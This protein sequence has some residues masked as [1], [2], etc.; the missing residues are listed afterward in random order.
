MFL[1]KI[2]IACSLTGCLWQSFFYA[3]VGY[4]AD[5]DAIIQLRTHLHP[6][7]QLLIG[8]E[9]T[10]TGVQVVRCVLTQMGRNY[11]IILSPP[12]RNR[13]LMATGKVDGLFL[14]TPNVELNKMGIATEPLALERWKFF[15][16]LAPLDTSIDPVPNLSDRIG[17]VL[18]SNEGSWLSQHRFEKTAFS[19]DM[20]SL[21]KVLL[22]KRVDYVLADEAAFYQAAKENDLSVENVGSSFVRYVPLVAHFSYDFLALNPTFLDEFNGRIDLCPAD[23][24][25]PT[26]TEKQRLADLAKAFASFEGLQDIIVQQANESRDR[27]LTAVTGKIITRRQQDV[28]WIEA[29]QGQQKTLTPFIKSILANSLSKKLKQMEQ[30]SQGKISEV[31]VFDDQ[32][33]ILGLSQITSDYWQGDE[34]KYRRIFD[35][36]EPINFSRIQFDSSARKFLV[37]VTMPIFNPETDRKIAAITFGFDAD[38]SLRDYAEGM[39]F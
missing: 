1:R 14:N 3:A 36:S 32:G 17:S 28:A 16:L 35:D 37:S 23:E 8:K 4:A 11:E 20:K 30:K 13:H 39:P 5:A 10:G 12:N 27:D 31:F 22:N 29:R 34:E 19:S 15:R 24:K 7:Y 38:I 2:C 33:Y 18:G 9:L 6:P 25:Q 26:V 21:I